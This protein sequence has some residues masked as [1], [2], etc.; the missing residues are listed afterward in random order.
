MSVTGTGGRG[1]GHRGLVSA[2]QS[3]APP[4]DKEIHITV[5]CAASVFLN[6]DVCDLN[7]RY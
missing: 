2:L 7:I 3:T 1:R 6:P 4:A 5:A